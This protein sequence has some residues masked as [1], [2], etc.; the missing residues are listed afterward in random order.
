MAPQTPTTEPGTL[1]ANTSYE[2]TR[3]SSD[4][5]ASDGWSLV[6]YFVGGASRF[7]VTADADGA[8]YDVAI[9]PADTEN[10][11]PGLYRWTSWFEL[12]G[13]RWADRSGVLTLEPDPV[14]AAAAPITAEAMVAAIEAR[15]VGRMEVGAD[16]EAYGAAGKSV[17]R[18][19]FEKLNYYLGIWR[20]KL[21]RQQHPGQSFPQHATR[22]RRAD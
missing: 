15:L 10:A 19:P 20:S 8:D 16:I 14:N 12:S 1:A 21:W 6:Y 22:F 4:Y 9:A 2:W 11:E 13:A 17:Q 7:T 18:I 3:S 5:P